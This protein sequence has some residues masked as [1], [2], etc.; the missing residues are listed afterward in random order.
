MRWTRRTTRRRPDAKGVRQVWI[1]YSNPSH[2]RVGLHVSQTRRTRCGKSGYERDLT[3]NDV[4]R[5][6]THQ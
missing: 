5:F 3:H 4:S 1:A 6:E 2:P